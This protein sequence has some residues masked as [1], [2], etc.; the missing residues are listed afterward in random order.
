MQPVETVE[1]KDWMTGSAV[2]AVLA[3]LAAGGAEARFVG[4][5]V[6]DSLASRP[7]RDI[8]I[9]T[10][11]RPERVVELIEAA[12]LK[13]V[14]TGLDHG[15]VTA[16]AEHQPFEITSLRED[17]E[18]DGR[19]AKVA[20]TDDWEADAARRDFTFNALSLAPD[21]RLYDPFEG[22]VDLT[23]GRVRFVGDP[24]A[25]IR[26]DYLRILRFFR[27]QAHY[28]R[29]EPERETLE[30]IRAEAAGIDGLSG[31]RLRVEMLKLL[32][33]ADPYPALAAMRDSGALARVLPQAD[34]TAL[35]CLLGLE[36]RPDP[37]LRLAALLPADEAAL[38]AT[39]QRL[40]LS[41]AERDRLLTLSAPGLAL[42]LKSSREDLRLGAYRLGRESLEDIL[43]LSAARTAAEGADLK[44]ALTRL[45]GWT[46]PRFPLQGRDLLELGC[47][48]GPA[49][50][51]TLKALEDWWIAEDYAP[52][53]EACLEEAKRRLSRR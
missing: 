29:E 12:G 3:A 52:D 15:T 22:R 44:E 30:A 4:G 49:L 1:L 50:G 38:R 48:P 37:L 53:R 11:A 35:A 7:I 51:R 19:R 8:D 28:G 6:R 36:P 40:R 47:E 41:N 42:T 39:A 9:A 32:A 5:C 13:A 20:F 23:A 10:P 26:E 31:E 25:R 46:A 2:T 43:L 33:A 45:G 24:V 27:F 18:T 14:P 34:L 16:V 17:I 21:G